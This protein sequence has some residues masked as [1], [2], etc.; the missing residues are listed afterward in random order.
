MV[1]VRGL[2]LGI[3]LVR[4]TWCVLMPFPTVKCLD[5]LVWPLKV[6]NT[7]QRLCQ[8]V[9]CKI[10]DSRGVPELTHVAHAKVIVILIPTAK[11]I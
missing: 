10:M 8:M 1:L 5:V 2:V 4:G 3:A 6:A 9:P 11:E 7:V